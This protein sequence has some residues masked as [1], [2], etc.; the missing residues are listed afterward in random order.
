MPWYASI[1]LVLSHVL[2]FVLG[3]LAYHGIRILS[4]RPIGPSVTK[5]GMSEA[6]LKQIADQMAQ[7]QVKAAAFGHFERFSQ[8]PP[9]REQYIP[10]GDGRNREEAF[11]PAVGGKK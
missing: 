6:R 4:V 8:P 7:T 2:V 5:P 9:A 11:A 1:L 10:E 3:A